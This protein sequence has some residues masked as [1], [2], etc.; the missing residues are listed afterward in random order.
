[1]KFEVSF[2]Y[3]IWSFLK[4]IFWKRENIIYI[5]SNKKNAKERQC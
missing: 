4:T 5:N 2:L 1:M 3:K